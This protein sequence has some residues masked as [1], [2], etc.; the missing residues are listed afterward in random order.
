MYSS[1]VYVNMKS[2][3]NSMGFYLGPLNLAAWT[4]SISLTLE[5]SSEISRLV[6]DT[7]GI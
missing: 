1:G 5:A 4:R 6:R 7:V 3:P 2:M